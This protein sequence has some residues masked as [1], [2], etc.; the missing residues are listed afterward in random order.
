MGRKFWF[1]ILGAFWL[2]MNVLLWRSEFGGGQELSS[3]VPAAM[4]W[5]RIL[6]APDDSTLEIDY[7]GKKVGYCRWITNVG[8]EVAMGKVSN[9]NLEL[10]GMVKRP[11]GYTADLEGNFVLPEGN[12][13]FRFEFHGRFGTNQ[14]W[15][16]LTA[17][18]ILKPTTWQAR[19]DKTTE[20]IELKMDDGS[21]EGWNRKVAFSDL[22]DP[23]KL[24]PALGVPMTPELLG[25]TA[26]TTN[27]TLTLKVEAHNDTV[28]IGHSNVRA[29][30]LTARLLDKY[31]ATVVVSK[32]GEI[33]RVE[34]PNGLVLVNDAFG[35]L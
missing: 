26:G 19:F 30:R 28:R 14:A 15:R 9:D 11:P 13:R 31:K 20:S 21:G 34:L 29:Y 3:S 12:N 27:L 23:G 4:V 25:Q 2:T 1:L 18:V 22:R 35:N 5:E 16:E 6:T 7:Q 8:E 17:R 32:V 10:E 33:M 24:L